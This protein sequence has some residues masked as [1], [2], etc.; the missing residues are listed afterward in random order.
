MTFFQHGL[1]IDQRC[2]GVARVV[3]HDQFN[4]PGALDRLLNALTNR[5]GEFMLLIQVGETD[6][7]SLGVARIDGD[8]GQPWATDGDL[9]PR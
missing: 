9:Y 6:A 5:H 2:V 8:L 1:C 3:G 4:V 7:P